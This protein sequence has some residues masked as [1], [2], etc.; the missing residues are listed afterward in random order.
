MTVSGATISDGTNSGNYNITYANNTTST[1]KKADVTLTA[2]DVEKTYDGT[3]SVTGGTLKVQSGTIFTGDSAS[4]GVFAFEDKNAGTGKVVTV[5]GATISDGTNNGNYNITYANNTTSTITPKTI[6]AS[7]ADISKTYDGTTDATAGA[8]TLNA[9]DVIG[10]DDVSLNESG[11]TAVYEDKNAGDGKTVNYNGLALSGAAA[12]NYSIATSATGTGVIYRKALELVADSVTIEEGYPM[13]ATF[14][15]SVTGFVA[16]E[17][18]GSGDA[19]LFALSDPSVTAVGSYG[20]TGTLNGNASGNYGL[21]YTFSNA[22]SNANA[23]EITA[24]P[25]SVED[26][27]V[28]DLIPAAKGTAAEDI[29]IT[30][31]DDAMEQASDKLAVASVGFAVSQGILPV[32]MD[33]GS[34]F[35]NTGMK[36]PSSMSTEEVAQQE[37]AQ[38]ESVGRTAAQGNGNAGVTGN[39]GLTGATYNSVVSNAGGDALNAAIDIVQK[40]DEAVDTEERKREKEAAEN[41]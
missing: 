27:T 12:N 38:Q 17:N 7:F 25:A 36:Q 2:E 1:I 24:K 16:G 22:A 11:I 3:T 33:R 37:Q 10:G 28:S 14:T 30:E 35:E 9:G 20:I 19:L 13:P 23:F 21:N 26:M 31:V 41:E 29:R 18:I 34:S 8:G 40:T 5:S 6:T 39:E 15:G 32:D 4:G